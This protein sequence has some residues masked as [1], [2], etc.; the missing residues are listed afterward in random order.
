MEI[1]YRSEYLFELEA[2]EATVI[3]EADRLQAEAILEAVLDYAKRKAKPVKK[4]KK[5]SENTKYYLT[6]SYK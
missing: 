4:A 6:N 5:P 2:L 3:S 1:K